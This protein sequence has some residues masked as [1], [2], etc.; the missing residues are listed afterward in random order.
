MYGVAI[1]HP[2]RTALAM[3][4]HLYT[5][6]GLIT[7]FL[8]ATWIVEGDFRRAFLAM[9]ASVV[10]DATDGTFARAVKVREF[11]PWINGRKL[12][13]IVDYLNYTLIPIFMIWQS[14][15]LPSPAWV[16]CTIPLIASA[17]AFVH[18]GAKE[19]D[20]GFFRGFPSYWN[21][22]VF[23]L[24]IMITPDSEWTVRPILLF[25]SLLCVTPIRFV[26]PNRPPCWKPLFLGGAILWA[27]NLLVILG[28]Y[29]A[30]QPWLVVTSLIY[31]VFYTIAS[32]FLDWADRHHRVRR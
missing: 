6:S 2:L 18:E 15:W 26:Y 8:A 13:D 16:W 19:D 11:T 21:I 20:R 29:P 9:F 28:S 30:I 12:D 3:L 10:I 25:L 14:D 5:A 23:Y 27:I 32:F 17:F 31:P 22:V 1:K 4:V 24:A 7:A